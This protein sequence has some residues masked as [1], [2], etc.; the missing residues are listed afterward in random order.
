MNTTRGQK[1][2]AT[3]PLRE[4]VP[5]IFLSQDTAYS[6]VP[7]IRRTQPISLAVF[8]YF[9]KSDSS[10]REELARYRYRYARCTSKHEPDLVG[11]LWDEVEVERRQ[12][13]EAL[14]LH[15]LQTLQQSSSYLQSRL[16]TKQ[17]LA[18]FL[19]FSLSVLLKLTGRSTFKWIVKLQARIK[20]FQ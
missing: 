2:H 13:G 3:V 16:N 12:Q 18:Q 5:V 4:G 1:S 8:L 14:L 20:I 9:S 7:R 19:L 17:E 6:P 15:L 11:G 10:F